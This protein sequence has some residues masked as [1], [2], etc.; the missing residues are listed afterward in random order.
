MKTQFMN[1]NF[2]FLFLVLFIKISYAQLSNPQV[3][4]VY[5]GRINYIHGYSLN[6]NTS[7]II[8]STES[9][10]S[11][12]YSDVSTPASS[13]ASF[14]RFAKVPSV[15]DD[16]GYGSG[17]NY[18]QVHNTSGTIYFA[19]FDKLYKTTVTAS[20]ATEVSNGPMHVP[21]IFSNNMLYSKGNQLYF[22]T[23]DASGNFSNNTSSP[24]NMPS[25]MGQHFFAFDVIN[26]YIY[27]FYPSNGTSG[28]KLY[29]SSSNFSTFNTSTSFID[30]SPSTL[31]TSIN[32]MAMNIAPD[33]RIYLAGSANG[34]GNKEIAYSDNDTIWTSINTGIDGAGSNYLSF[35]GDASNYHVYYTKAA[36]NNKGMLG[37]WNVFGSTGMQTH[38]NDG[39]VYSDPNDTNIVYLTTDQGI[40]ASINEGFT[41]FEINDG[42]E[43]VQVNDFDMTT[44]KSTAWLAS[45]AGIRKVSNYLTSPTWT[46][47]IFPNNDGSP[48]YSSEMISDTNKVYVGNV[49]VYRTNNGGTTWAQKFSPESAPWS[50]TGPVICEAIE[51]CKYDTSIVFAGYTIQ[52]TDKGG[53]FYSNNSGNTWSQLNLHLTSGTGKDVDVNDIVFT[54]EGADTVAYVGVDYDL[55]SPTGRSIY[56]IVKSS[57]SWIASQDMNAGNTS[58]G[59]LIVASIKDLEVSST[60]DTIYASGTDAG[61]NHPIAYYKPINSTNKWTPFTTNGFPFV[62]G[63]QGK[64]ITLG[65]D[66]VYVAVDNEVYNLGLSSTSWNLGYAYPNGTQIYVMY[67]DELLVGTGTGLYGHLGNNSSQNIHQNLNTKPV[68][69]PNPNNGKI[70]IKL[71]KKYDSIQI[72]IYDAIGQ[73]IYNQEY[74]NQDEISI[75]AKNIYPQ[76]IYYLKLKTNEFD[77]TQ[78][79]LI[80]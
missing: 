71:D 18:F 19:T 42:V 35:S 58:T 24:I 10:N 14:S 64:A 36:S 52:G 49:R 4:N 77:V 16:N 17:I 67:F 1:V 65:N 15:D 70:N 20:V 26:G 51:V 55:T 60:G 39:A 11:M 47:A 38:P 43:A 56:R 45:K 12:F 2:T 5:G 75:E 22:G 13:S 54:K 28:F 76:S 21:F 50:W 9:A 40:G 78:K 68:I 44:D 63:K 74:T 62:S 27:L 41:I 29:K 46:N 3:E 31:S 6:A 34:P 66:T 32:W 25:T 37:S 48:Y 8:I 57:S 59:S 79:L 73:M 30:I 72:K 33:G 23:L 69:Y 53:L 61:I 80:K 7:R